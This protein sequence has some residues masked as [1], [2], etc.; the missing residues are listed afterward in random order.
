VPAVLPDNT[1]TVWDR[2]GAVYVLYVL[3]TDGTLRATRESQLP[4]IG[5]DYAPL[6]RVLHDE[7]VPYEPQQPGAAAAASGAWSGG[8]VVAVGGSISGGVYYGQLLSGSISGGVS[9]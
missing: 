5:S 2:T 3:K 8:A 7:V 1:S 4:G 6:A 9:S